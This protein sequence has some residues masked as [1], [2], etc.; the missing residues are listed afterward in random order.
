MAVILVVEDNE[1]NRDVLLRWFEMND[2]DTL[3]AEYGEAGVEI[4]KIKKPDYIIMDINLPDISGLEA[5]KKIKNFPELKDIKIIVLTAFTY[6][7]QKRPDELA[8]CDAYK[9]KPV[10]LDELLET[11]ESI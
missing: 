3:S 7:G 5:I 4:A 2:Y 1:M 9:T 8:L 10:D 6:N 11:I